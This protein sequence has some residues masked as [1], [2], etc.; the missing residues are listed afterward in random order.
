MAI[1]R[2]QVFDQS[3]KKAN[4][5]ID[6]YNQK[7]I[8]IK[9]SLDSLDR[10]NDYD[11][12]GKLLGEYEKY[13]SYLDNAQKMKQKLNTIDRDYYTENVQFGSIVETKKNYYF[14]ATALGEIDMDNGSTVYA[15]STEAPIFEKMKGKK[16]GETFNLNNEEI[17]ILKIH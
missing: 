5:Q 17:E 2:R 10:H 3:L 11:E 16:A 9:D 15:V 1:N 13:S 14:I 4:D 6:R 12:E 8:S 7:L